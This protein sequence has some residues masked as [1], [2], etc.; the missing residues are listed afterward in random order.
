M[1]SINQKSELKDSR[2]LKRLA[3]CFKSRFEGSVPIRFGMFTLFTKWKS[4]TFFFFL[5][6]FILFISALSSHLSFICLFLSFSLRFLFSHFLAH[7]S[8]AV[9]FC[10]FVFFLIC[11]FLAANLL[12]PLLYKHNPP[13]LLKANTLL[14]FFALLHT[15]CT[16]KILSYSLWMPCLFFF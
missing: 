16:S 14:M 5:A 10:F 12:Y 6:L 11:V 3:S 7:P 2:C 9:L 13:R 8:S 4:N 1:F 15:I